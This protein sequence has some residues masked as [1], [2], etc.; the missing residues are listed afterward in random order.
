MSGKLRVKENKKVEDGIY[1]VKLTKW[2][3]KDGK[4]GGSYYNFAFQIVENEDFDGEYVGHNA[5]GDLKVG[6]KL[7]KILTAL[8][9]GAELEI[10][11]EIDLDDYKG[12]KCM[13]TVTSDEDSEYAKI[14]SFKA[15]KKKVVTEDEEPAPKKKV[16]TEDEEEPAPKKKKIVSEDEEEAPKKKKPVDDDEEF[17]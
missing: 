12:K 9:G 15:I 10:N 14:V 4:N 16:V 5:P 17:K 7:Y 1:K 11:D 2:Q 8:N 3:E 13:V 6:N